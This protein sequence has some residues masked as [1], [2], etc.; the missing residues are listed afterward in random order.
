MNAVIC[1]NCGCSFA[2]TTRLKRT[3]FCSAKCRRTITAEQ[4]FKNVCWEWPDKV[5]DG[6][7][8]FV[9]SQGRYRMAHRLAWECSVGPIP[10]GMKVCHKCDN[11]RCINPNHLFLGTDADNV[12][13]MD[14]KG[15]RT[16]LRGSENGYARLD[17]EKVKGIKKL[18]VET[19]LKGTEIAKAYNVHQSTI[20]QI[21]HGRTWRHV[22][23]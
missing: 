13:D 1:K 14:A 17:E 5:N 15:R 12:A 8:G 23:S 10:D 22:G 7:Y 3:N 11:R 9:V 6:G 2:P 18:L 20:W 4:K 19:S 16:V 21:K